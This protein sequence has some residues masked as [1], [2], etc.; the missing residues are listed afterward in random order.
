VSSGIWVAASGAIARATALDS[1]ANNLAN[2]TT[3]G[4]KAE[5]A[6]FQEH[7]IR[8][9]YVGQAR[10]AMRYAS[11]SE[12]AIDHAAGPIT[13]TQ[14]NLDVALAGP[15]FFV[16]NTPDGERYTRSGSFHLGPTGQ[17]LSTDGYPVAGASGPLQVP[18]NEGDPSFGPDGSLLVGQEMR[19]QLKIVKFPNPD[20]LERVGDRMFRATARS[21]GAQSHNVAVESGALE[22][23]NVSVVKGMT[24]LVS[25][26][27]AF[28][29]LQRAVEAFSE[30]ERRAAN[31]IA[32]IG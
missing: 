9:A 20:K 23:S 28:E 25:A 19:G 31:E 10:P 6:L 21:G 27:R 2:A 18:P 7:L 16:L 22:Q 3:S 24:E 13:V 29:A 4:F 5:R 26:T 32:R 17:L 15:G 30:V 12:N 8:A 1:T 11:V 14:R